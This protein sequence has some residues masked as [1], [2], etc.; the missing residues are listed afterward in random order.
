MP[1]PCKL[2]PIHKCQFLANCCQLPSANTLPTI[3]NTF[4]TVVNSQVPIPC[5]LLP[6]HRC[7]YLANCCRFRIATLE[8]ANS[9]NSQVPR[10]FKLISTQK[11]PTKACKPLQFTN[12][13]TLQPVATSEVQNQ[14]LKVP[15]TCELPWIQVLIAAHVSEFLWVQNPKRLFK[16]H[17][18]SPTFTSVKACTLLPIH[19]CQENC[20]SFTTCKLFPIHHQVGHWSFPKYGPLLL[21]HKM[22]QKDLNT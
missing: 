12:A 9:F 13:N 2:L 19:K 20:S 3:A 1:I 17:T 4:Q 22:D 8:L 5:K 6:I 7:Q 21:C 14:S 15:R 18:A 10:L 16:A 11:C